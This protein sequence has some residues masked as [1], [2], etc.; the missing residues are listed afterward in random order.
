LN[1][2]TGDLATNEIIK[3]SREENASMFGNKTKTSDFK[4]E[5]W[6]T[7]LNPIIDSIDFTKAQSKEASEAIQKLGDGTLSMGDF[8]SQFGVELGLSESQVRMTKK[9][10]GDLNKEFTDSSMKNVGKYAA[11]LLDLNKNINETATQG[12]KSF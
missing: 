2:S 9:T 8:I 10:Y 12:T 11:A 4:S 6:D 7:F 3:K 1:F 5:N